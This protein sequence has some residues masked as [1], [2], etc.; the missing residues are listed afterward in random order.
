MEE[1]RAFTFIVNSNLRI[2][3]RRANL[4]SLRQRLQRWLM[5]FP[6]NLEIYVFAESIRMFDDASTSR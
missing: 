6:K 5:P 1:Q 3:S 2:L 4:Q